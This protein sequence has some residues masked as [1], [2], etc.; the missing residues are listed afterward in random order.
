[1]S[2]FLISLTITTAITFIF[3]AWQMFTASSDVM[4][5]VS[6]ISMLISYSGLLT[7]NVKLYL[8]GYLIPVAFLI[9]ASY[10]HLYEMETNAYA[11]IISAYFPVLCAAAATFSYVVLSLCVELGKSFL[12]K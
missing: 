9:C 6:A 3:D 2:L 1:M 12:V 7:E 5:G 4:F 8:S 10:F 11:A